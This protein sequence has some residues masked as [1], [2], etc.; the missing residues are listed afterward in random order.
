M[1]ALTLTALCGSLLAMLA[2]IWLGRRWR[3]P[4]ADALLDA[5]GR[6][7]AGDLSARVAL[8]DPPDSPSGRL[9]RAFNAMA[10]RT[11]AQ[12]GE[13]AELRV[14]LEA[15]VAR[16]VSALAAERDRI[17]AELADRDAAAVTL[18]EAQK[19]QV[20][21]QLAGG[22]AHDFNNLLTAIVGALDLLR[23]RLPPAQEPLLRLVDSALQAAERGSRLTG[24]LLIFSRRQRLLPVPTDINMTLLALS[25]LLG[26][27]LGR[28]V[29]VQTDLVQD[30]WPAMIDPSQ[31]EAAI[32]NLVAN[33]RDAMPEGG[34]L[35]IA[36]RNRSVAVGGRTPPGDYVVL[37]VSDTGIGMPPEVLARAFE[38]FF[39][40]APAGART[41]LGL[42]Q[43]H[44]LV[45]QSGG[46]V[47]LESRPGAGTTVTLLLPRAAGV[48]A[49]RVAA[50]AGAT[51][52]RPRVLVVDDDRDVRDMIGE[53]L[54][55]RG[56]EVVVLADPFLALTMLQQEP[57]FDLLLVDYVM[58][59]MNGGTLI[60]QIQA[61]RPGQRALL[62]TGNPGFHPD[63]AIA[64]ENV[65][66]KPF[67]IARLGER[68]ERALA[69]PMLRALPGG[70]MS[71]PG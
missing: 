60:R 37:R 5:V 25:D 1:A 68:L 21:G 57:G 50:P 40:G 41:G 70:L 44:G 17:A 55:G 63:E 31:I 26:S 19:L 24:Q 56:Y 27:T 13:L 30:L 61:L 42:S 29:R 35:T 69:R 54:T 36:T 28:A 7:T 8:R 34:V 47:R 3:R 23:G 62:M 22:I 65:I 32:I 43:V 2:G 38:P 58:P 49:A 4:H 53:M 48:P 9:A 64:A 66:R 46:E 67:T 10:A 18:C 59:G 52:G 45:G 51:R 11:A 33:A 6:W 16:R 39:T 20:V 14:T 12:Q 71:P 15:E